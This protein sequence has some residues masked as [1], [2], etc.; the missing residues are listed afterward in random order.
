MSIPIDGLDKFSSEHFIGFGNPQAE[1]S[2][3]HFFH[4]ISFVEPL[5][6]VKRLGVIFHTGIYGLTVALRFT[7]NLL[8]LHRDFLKLHLVW[9]IIPKLLIFFNLG[10]SIIFSI[11]TLL[12]LVLSGKE[13]NIFKRKFSERLVVYLAVADILFRLVSNK[14]SSELVSI[15]DTLWRSFNVTA[16]WLTWWYNGITLV[17]NARDRCRDMNRP[18]FFRAPLD[19]IYRST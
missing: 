4:A 14:D 13:R 10:T 1:K 3:A 9:L 7:L 18:P 17:Q 16:Q 19:L 8:S 12:F 5:K 6:I 2:L 15:K 11:G